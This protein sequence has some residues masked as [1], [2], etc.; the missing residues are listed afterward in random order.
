MSLFCD[1]IRDADSEVPGVKVFSWFPVAC[2]GSKTRNSMEVAEPGA[3]GA[4]NWSQLATR[5]MILEDVAFYHGSRFLGDI[6]IAHYG[7]V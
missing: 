3:V 1:Q 6:L 7:I 4:R 5:N 2:L